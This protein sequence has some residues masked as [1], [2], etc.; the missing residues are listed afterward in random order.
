[1]VNGACGRVITALLKGSVPCR[2]WRDGLGE[3]I[4]HRRSHTTSDSAWNRRR[5]FLEA[6][7][8]HVTELL[9]R[10]AVRRSVG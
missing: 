3:R 6:R 8:R 10:G 7:K 1:M 9:L 4:A 2:R 5:K